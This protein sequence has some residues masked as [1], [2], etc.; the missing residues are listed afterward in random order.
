MN[1]Y[2]PIRDR[3]KDR[4]V[5]ITGAGNGIGRCISLRFAE[6]GANCAICDLDEQS[7]AETERIIKERGGISTCFVFDVGDKDKV[8][9]IVEDIIRKHE[10]IHVLVNCAGIVQERSCVDMSEGEWKKT[11]AVNLDG[12]FYVTQPVLKNMIK[13]KYGKIVNISSQSGVFGRKNRSAYSASK[14]GLNGFSRSLALEVAPYRINVNAVCPSRIVSAMTEKILKDR[15]DATGMPYS[16][17]E[18]AYIKSVPIGR[19]GLPEDVASLTTYLASD[20]ASF[21]TGQLISTSGGR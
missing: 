3:F 18:G 12:V 2:K 21:I 6:E 11:M 20:E 8:E 7:L 13:F 9:K 19:L 10:Q 17:V 4:V 15:A 16:E 5:L 14:A 1:P